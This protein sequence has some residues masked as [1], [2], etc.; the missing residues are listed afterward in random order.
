MTLN[1]SCDS[2]ILFSYSKD[3]RFYRLFINLSPS[4]CGAGGCCFFDGFWVIKRLFF[5]FINV[6]LGIIAGGGPAFRYEHI[7]MLEK[8][9]LF[10]KST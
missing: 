3:S 2:L 6:D 7:G 4:L 8:R 9:L 10:N 5:G 1:A